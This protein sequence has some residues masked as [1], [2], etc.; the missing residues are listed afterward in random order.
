MITFNT[1]GCDKEP[2]ILTCISESGVIDILI[3]T[4]ISF[5][6]YPR[7][8]FCETLRLLSHKKLVFCFFFFTHYNSEYTSKSF[9]I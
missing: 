3:G 9:R 6:K 2:D 4:N 1:K 8:A 7:A 5:P